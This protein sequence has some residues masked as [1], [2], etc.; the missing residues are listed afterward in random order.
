MK[1]G[2]V[3]NPHKSGAE[4][5]LDHL[6]T[7]LAEQGIASVLEE[8]TASLLDGE[9]GVPGPDLAKEVDVIAVLGGDGT[10]LHAVA[11]LGG[12]DKPIAGINI[13]T[14]GFLTSCTE[15]RDR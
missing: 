11:M 1:V 14:L 12:T 5:T 6:V 7:V 3:A 13:G 9:A 15:C 8:H 10:M 4:K 2:I